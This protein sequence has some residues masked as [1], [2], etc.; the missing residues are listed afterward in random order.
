[1][2]QLYPLNDQ[3]QACLDYEQSLLVRRTKRARIHTLLSRVFA[4]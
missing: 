1:M 4:A 2:P 3:C